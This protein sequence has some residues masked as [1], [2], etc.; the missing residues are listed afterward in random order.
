M[1]ILEIVVHQS[2]EKMVLAD[3]AVSYPKNINTDFDT[4][5]TLTLES[6]LVDSNTVPS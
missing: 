3:G 6:S 4:D 1:V 2:G 5:Q